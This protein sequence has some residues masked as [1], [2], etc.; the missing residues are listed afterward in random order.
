MVAN[1]IFLNNNVHLLAL[2]KS[3]IRRPH[4]KRKLV[5]L[6]ITLTRQFQ[7]SFNW[8]GNSMWTATL[9]AFFSRSLLANIDTFWDSSTTQAVIALEA[10]MHFKLNYSKQTYNKNG[11]FSSIYKNKHH[12]NS[13]WPPFQHILYFRWLLSIFIALS[14]KV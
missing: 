6:K 11:K 3:V 10:K 1:K 8:Q 13:C 4:W 12:E 2:Q 9:I 7:L 14:I 5:P